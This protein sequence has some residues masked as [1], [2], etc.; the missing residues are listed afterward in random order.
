M[1]SS[2][3][4]SSSKRENLSY[5]FLACVADRLD[6]VYDDRKSYTLRRSEFWWTFCGKKLWIR[7]AIR[8]PTHTSVSMRHVGG[9]NISISPTH[10]AIWHKFNDKF[11]SDAVFPSLFLSQPRLRGNQILVDSNGNCLR[12]SFC[13]MYRDVPA[14]SAIVA[15]LREYDQKQSE[16]ETR[17]FQFQR[18][19]FIEWG[20]SH[21]D[22]EFLRQWPPLQT[23][24]AHVYYLAAGILE[25]SIICFNWIRNANISVHDEVSLKGWEMP[26]AQSTL[27]CGPHG[28]LCS[29]RVYVDSRSCPFV[30]AFITWYLEENYL[31]STSSRIQ[32]SDYSTNIYHLLQTLFKN[33]LVCLFSRRPCL[34]TIPIKFI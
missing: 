26:D 20:T 32:I 34:R 19:H 31:R 17:C 33:L 28:K 23:H 22:L 14:P 25:K 29:I 11:R 21:M 3:S 18:S 12:V 15:M 16:A 2:L 30:S 10:Y 1:R 24:S 7:F 5:S 9:Q 27:F 13:R 6:A 8:K 4:F